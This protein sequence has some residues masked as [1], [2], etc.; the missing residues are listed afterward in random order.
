MNYQ[1]YGMKKPLPSYEE[2]C[3]RPPHKWRNDFWLVC[4]A[5]LR[6]GMRVWMAVFLLLFCLFG[7]ALAYPWLVMLERMKP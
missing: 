6:R 1:H 2:A 7:L 5:E 4:H 3:S